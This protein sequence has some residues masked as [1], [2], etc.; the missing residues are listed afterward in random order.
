MDN[1]IAARP[2]GLAIMLPV[3]AVLL[4]V[5]NATPY[6]PLQD[7]NEWVY[8]GFVTSQLL[9][10]HLSDRF[11]V[12]QFPVPNSAVQVVLALLCLVMSAP[13]AA[14]VLA[15]GYVIAAAAIAWRLSLK[16]APT[17]NR[18]VFFLLLIG[19]YFNSPFWNGYMNYQLGILLF[20]LWLLIDPATRR[21]PLWILA[22]TVAA[23]FTHAM[24]WA[25]LMLVIGVDALRQRRFRALLAA[26]PALVSL[27]L[28]G[29]YAACK[30]TPMMPDPNAN[31]GLLHVVAYKLYTLAK[32]GPYH[33]YVY[34]ADVRGF[35][36]RVIY[37]LGCAVNFAFA[38]G[39][40]VLLWSAFARPLLRR[41]GWR[42][43]STE[44]I[45]ALLL[46]GVSLAMPAVIS[47]LVNPG[48]RVLYPALLLALAAA[49]GERVARIA[50]WLAPG[51]VVL[52][53]CALGLALNG[54]RL[55]PDASMANVSSSGTPPFFQSRPGAYFDVRPILSGVSPLRKVAFETGYL[56]NRQPALRA[57][58]QTSAQ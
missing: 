14:Q 35:G 12:A 28:F 24:I 20:S 2:N 15:S 29:W 11:L 27:A 22:F 49:N 13:L 58:A 1:A 4:F 47:D 17:N 30:H 39:V 50:N 19:V 57:Q 45:G 34:A 36:D 37:Y 10:G 52:A 40:V 5:M 48:E 8:Q 43:A 41:E 32:L 16:I 3:V 44:Q 56:F 7:Y 33:N 26:C 25:S 53:A 51:V 18:G 31:A 38:A 42:R 6:V 46:L 9:Q 55:V 21:K 23:F 54:A